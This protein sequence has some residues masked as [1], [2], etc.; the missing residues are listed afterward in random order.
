MAVPDGDEFDSRA[1]DSST[2]SNLS[3]FSHSL[4][5]PLAYKRSTRPLPV[6]PF[7]PPNHSPT[8][9]RA[10][11]EEEAER[12][13]TSAL[14]IL[15]EPLIPG[16]P[17]GD[18]RFGTTVASPETMLRTGDVVLAIGSTLLWQTGRSGGGYQSSAETAR[19]SKYLMYTTPGLFG[20]VLESVEP[21]AEAP[22]PSGG[23][24]GI[25]L[26]K[27]SKNDSSLTEKSWRCLDYLLGLR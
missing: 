20:D 14:A 18:R 26:I 17:R 22:A 4:T 23:G 6:Y 10:R 27:S 15:C 3:P 7:H 2:R 25:T 24:G 9:Q 5:F 16:L 19:V 21:W 12:W 13:L 11:F 1:G 8:S